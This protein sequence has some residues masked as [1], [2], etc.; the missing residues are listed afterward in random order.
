MKPAY[1][2]H[3]AP[4]KKGL[5]R[6]LR[7]CRSPSGSADVDRERLRDRWH[8][9]VI[10]IREFGGQQKRKPRLRSQ[11][12][13]GVRRD[14][15]SQRGGIGRKGCDGSLRQNM[16]GDHPPLPAAVVRRRIERFFCRQR[17]RRAEARLCLFRGRAGAEIGGGSTGRLRIGS[18]VSVCVVWRAA[19][20]VGSGGR[21]SPPR[22]VLE[23]NNISERLTVGVTHNKTGRRRL[24]GPGGRDAAFW[25]CKW[26]S[27]TALLEPFLLD[28][29][30]T[31]DF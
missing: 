14:R 24:G 1:L 9:L 23:I 6:A 12:Q 19:P 18:L 2:C 30:W 13:V 27:E 5:R 11:G 20:L 7:C 26:G 29:F 8:S 3:L 31:H 28:L 16:I 10:M 25:H 17:P 15:S 21:R 4:T 22:L